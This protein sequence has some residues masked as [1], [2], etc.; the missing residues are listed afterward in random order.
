MQ[1][2]G[3][4]LIDETDWGSLS[5]AYA[6][7][8]DAPAQ[9]RA[10]V[11]DDTEARAAAMDYLWGAI[12]HQGTPWTVT[13]TVALVVAGLLDDPALD[14]TGQ[15]TVLGGSVRSF[16]AHLIDFLAGVLDAGRPD[17]GDD[18]LN[19]WLAS[20]PSDRRMDFNGEMDEATMNAMYAT[21]I[22]GC[23]EIAPVLIGSILT[24]LGSRDPSVRSSAAAAA[25]NAAQLPVMSVQRDDIVTRLSA[26]AARPDVGVDE[27][28][29][30]VLAI[31]EMGGDTASFLEDRSQAV[32][33]CAALAPSLSASPA[34]F[35]EL[36][37][38]LAHPA[39]IDDWFGERPPQFDMRPRFS[40]VRA[41]IERCET[42]DQIVDAAVAIARAT[43]KY[44]VDSEWGPLLVAAF[45][46]HDLEVDLSPAQVSY[47][48]AVVDNEDLWDPENGNAVK[49]FRKAEL[50]RDRSECAAIVRAK[51]RA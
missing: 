8:N 7:A 26:A 48:A 20:G 36:M 6:P 14:A 2:I 43:S 40:F 24:Q 21:A 49:W 37:T 3:L 9:L 5:H 16:R 42:F 19:S 23:R 12:L 34:A 4:A 47:L 35:Q 11:G 30:L 13:P 32:R 41:V 46:S 29:T 45:P 1:R 22:Q 27:R 28:S 17:I 51:R 50:P 10:L 39:E 44:C 31:G 38:A 15:A 25:A 33:C 18:Q